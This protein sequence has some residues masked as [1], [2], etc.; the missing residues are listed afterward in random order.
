MRFK[1]DCYLSISMH[2]RLGKEMLDQG[3]HAQKLCEDLGL[4]PYAPWGDEAVNPNR[5]IDKCPAKARMKWYVKKDD[6]AVDDSR[7]LLLLTGDTATS[8]TLWETARMYY[9]NHR[10]I[11][12][13]S[14]KMYDKVL[15]NFTTIKATKVFATPAQ[16][17][18]YIKRRTPCHS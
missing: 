16:A 9:R 10:P 15:C 17:I 11:Y 3:S 2:G 6:K 18:R 7:C 5:I 4:R 13:V 1:Y 12:V 8:G 14:P